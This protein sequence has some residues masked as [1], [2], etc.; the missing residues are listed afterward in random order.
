MDAVIYSERLHTYEGKS[1]PVSLHFTF[2][3]DHYHLARQ[4]VNEQGET[5]EVG[6]E[7]G[8]DYPAGEVPIEILRN[9]ADSKPDIDYFGVRELK[10]RIN[11]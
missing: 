2:V 11:Y 8:F 1:F 10:D 5:I 7:G 6:T 3:E 4:I 9:N